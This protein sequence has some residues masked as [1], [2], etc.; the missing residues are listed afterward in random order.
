MSERGRRR[1]MEEIA[2]YLP[3]VCCDDFG[4]GYVYEGCLRG[5]AAFRGCLTASLGGEMSCFRG[6]RF[7]GDASRYGRLRKSELS[8]SEGRSRRYVNTINAQV[9]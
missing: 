3:L 2:G 4:C 6:W 9:S 7:P 1:D 5:S 8:K